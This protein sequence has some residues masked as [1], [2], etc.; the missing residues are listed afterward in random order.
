M[1]QLNTTTFLQG[2]VQSPLVQTARQAAFDSFQQGQK[3]LPVTQHTPDQFA[4]YG[5]FGP[6]VSKGCELTA[7]LGHIV[8]DN[9]LISAGIAGYALIIGA[10][11]KYG[12]NLGPNDNVFADFENFVDNAWFDIDK[13]LSPNEETRHIAV[14]H[15][16]HFPHIT[17][18]A[19]NFLLDK[20]YDDTL[21]DI[22]VEEPKIISTILL[23]GDDAIKHLDDRYR[24]MASSKFT[25]KNIF[26]QFCIRNILYKLKTPEASTCL[27]NIDEPREE[28]P[29]TL[30]GNTP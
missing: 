21:K 26:L 12:W 27:Q 22:S 10:L 15:F 13:L 25:A 1:I 5:P 9:P 18:D 16:K 6:A 30:F 3:L 20:L 24:K 8:M 19:I 17:G 4:R 28:I 14:T 23:F 7:D 2:F 11:T 29:F